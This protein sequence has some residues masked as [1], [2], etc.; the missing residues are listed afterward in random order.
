MSYFIL[1]S[2]KCDE[3][4]DEASTSTTESFYKIPCHISQSVNHLQDSLKESLNEKIEKNSPSL[5]RQAMYTKSSLVDRLPKYLTMNF[6]RFFWKP[7]ERIKAKILRVSA[8]ASR[9]VS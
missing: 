4:A 3:A 8:K 2:L 7:V 6:V 1:D 5:N 9:L